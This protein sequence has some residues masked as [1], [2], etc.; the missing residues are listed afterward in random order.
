MILANLT[1]FSHNLIMKMLAQG[2]QHVKRITLHYVQILQFLRGTIDFGYRGFGKAI[3]NK[4][5][6]AAEEQPAE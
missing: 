1:E 5:K 3:I 6:M 2:I 4:I